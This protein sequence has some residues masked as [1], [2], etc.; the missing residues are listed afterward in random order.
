MASSVISLCY[1]GTAGFAPIELFA[2]DQE[3]RAGGAMNAAISPPPK[4]ELFAALTIASTSIF[5]MSFL[6]IWSGIY[7]PPA[8]A[9]F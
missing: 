8:K 9:A 4:R 5:V 2:F 1:L 3:F 6:T 7:E